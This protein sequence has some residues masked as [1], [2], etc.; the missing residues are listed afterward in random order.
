MKKFL[1]FFCIISCLFFA[2][3]STLPLKFN[4]AKNEENNS[5]ILYCSNVIKPMADS[6]VKDVNLNSKYKIEIKTI[7]EAEVDSILKKGKEA[8]VFIGFE[9]R[10]TE[11]IAIETIGKDGIGII[12]SAGSK[13]ENINFEN[14]RDIYSGKV[15]SE[16]RRVGKE[17]RSRWSPYH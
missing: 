3:C 5:L 9:E 2:A 12:T 11:N 7:D 4:N 15:R 10:Q 16:E 6:I 8:C 1:A 13:L 14:L 17:C